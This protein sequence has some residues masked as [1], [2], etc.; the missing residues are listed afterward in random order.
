ME[1]EAETE[2]KTDAPRSLLQHQSK[3]TRKGTAPTI[4]AASENRGASA[5]VV[6]SDCLIQYRW[7]TPIDVA[8]Y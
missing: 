7:A 4:I 5:A 8:F 2:A 1:V 3:I 6:A